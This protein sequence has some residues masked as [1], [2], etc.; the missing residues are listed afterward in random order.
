[1]PE[2]SLSGSSGRAISAST[3]PS[4]SSCRSSGGYAGARPGLRE[5]AGELDGLADG[6]RALEGRVGQPEGRLAALGGGSGEE[7]Q[8][9]QR[10]RQE[11]ARAREAS[12]DA[13]A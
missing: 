3:R 7:Y 5:W 9:L 8:Q 2:P 6:R 12:E 1:M 10:A 13:E 4:S 11:A